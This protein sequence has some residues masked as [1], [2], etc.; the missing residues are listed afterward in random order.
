MAIHPHR[1]GC[2]AAHRK[3]HH[4]LQVHSCVTFMSGIV[5]VAWCILVFSVSTAVTQCVTI[6]GQF[7]LNMN[8]KARV[9]LL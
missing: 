7:C 4:H 6:A 5:I 1:M 8:H 9:V 3:Y 2:K